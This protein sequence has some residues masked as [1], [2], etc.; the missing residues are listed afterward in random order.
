MRERPSDSSSP[1][2]RGSIQA[3]LEMLFEETVDLADRLKNQARRTH[4]GEGLSPNGRL[5]LQCLQLRG[6]QSVPA[7][8]HLRS[9]TRQNIQALVDRLAEAGYIAFVPNPGHKRS[10]LVS[11]TDAGRQLLSSAAERE[12]SLLATLLPHTTEAE[13]K[14]AAELLRRLRLLLG[15]ERKLWGRAAADVLPLQVSPAAAPSK[16]MGPAEEELPVSL[17]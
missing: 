2:R 7:L 1:P 4:R 12:A 13:L 6:A 8:A 14:A 9:S 5:L 11:L 10:D 3:E 17:L 16:A 15:G